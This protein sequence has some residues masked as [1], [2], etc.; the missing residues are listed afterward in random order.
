MNRGRGNLLTRPLLWFGAAGVALL[1]LPTLGYG[2]TG[3]AFFDFEGVDPAGPFGPE[4]NRGELPFGPQRYILQAV[5]GGI[6]PGLLIQTAQ[7]G[8]PAAGNNGP[9]DDPIGGPGN[10]SAVWDNNDHFAG[11]PDGPTNATMGFGSEVWAADAAQFTFG[12][13]EYDIWLDPAPAAGRTY[14]EHRV[15][16]GA[17]DGFVSTVGDTTA[18]YSFLD[19]GGGPQIVYS[20]LGNLAG[21]PS[22]MAGAVNHIVVD[23][24]P[25]K[26]HTVSVNGTTVTWTTGG[27][28]VTALPWVDP[29]STGVNEM[30]FVTDFQGE[31]GDPHGL[32]WIDNVRITTVPEPAGAALALVGAL[33]VAAFRRR[34]RQADV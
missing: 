13:I 4:G 19:T 23:I 17:N 29:T 14:M 34:G 30:T 1:A 18:R 5:G 7:D 12:K 28:P 27:G 20:G 21:S 8:A 10:K 33:A 9:F 22:P 6:T 26:T 24:L 15:G 2:Q 11:T 32:V 31:P 3:N 16:F 25:N